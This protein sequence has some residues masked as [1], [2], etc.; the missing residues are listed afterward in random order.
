MNTNMRRSRGITLME[1]MVVMAIIGIL[2]AIATPAYQA[3]AV[4]THRAAAR[5]CLM[6][7]AQF[8]ERSYTTNLTYEM[9]DDPV[10][11]C[12]SESGMEE[13]Y[14]FALDPDPTQSTYTAVATPINAQEDRDTLCA[15]LTLDQTGARDASGT[16]GA[17]EC[18]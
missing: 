5:A 9:D 2:A 12:A 17:G 16:G 15:V 13:F 1:L 8:M 14:T 11:G 10:M 4:R 7:M 6:E 18:W 3:Y